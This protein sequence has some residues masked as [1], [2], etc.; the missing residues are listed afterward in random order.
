MRLLQANVLV[1]FADEDEQEMADRMNEM[2]DEFIVETGYDAN[3][4][5]SIINIDEEPVRGAPPPKKKRG[6]KR[7]KNGGARVVALG[8]VPS[9]S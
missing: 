7:K 1:V 4:D 8:P 3:A 9:S 2:I 6:G 5:V